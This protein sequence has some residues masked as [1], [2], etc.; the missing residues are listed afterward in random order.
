MSALASD[1]MMIMAAGLG[2][3][4]RPLTLTMP[5]PL[6]HVAGK[7]LI[8]YVLDAGRD[9]RIARA[10]VNVHYLA[11]MMEAHLRSDHGLAITISDERGELLETGG[12][13]VKAAPALPDPFF[14]TNADNIWRDG[15][16]NIFTQLSRQW[17]A[18]RMDA[19]LLLV[20][21]DRSHNFTSQG[22]FDLSAHGKVSRRQ[23]DCRAQY[24][25]TGVQLVSHRLLRDPPQGK[26]STNILWDRAINE[27]RLYGIAYDGDVYEVGK[28]E[29]I[30]LTEEALARA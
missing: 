16:S 5:K 15:Q 2:T 29:N 13:M 20:S 28:P 25:Y 21:H 7:P 11:D 18:E 24:I 27:G 6:V 4:M 1:T 23:Q 22:D 9:A 19:L 17:D 30:A 3:R 12:G 8:D 14:C 10:V 26:F